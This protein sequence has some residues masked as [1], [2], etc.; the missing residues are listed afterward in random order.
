[1]QALLHATVRA[2]VKVCQGL[3]CAQDP[4]SMCGSC[5]SHILRLLPLS[6]RS[7]ALCTKCYENKERELILP[8]KLED[9]SRSLFRLDLVS[10]I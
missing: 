6:S 2:G 3:L 4:D 1:M 8:E 9:I 10:R 7:I 5:Y